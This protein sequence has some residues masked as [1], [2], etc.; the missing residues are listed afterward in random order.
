MIFTIVLW[1]SS[2]LD[3]VSSHYVS[4]ETWQQSTVFEYLSI[5]DFIGNE[6]EVL[7][8][9][10]DLDFIRLVLDLF[11]RYRLAVGLTWYEI[12]SKRIF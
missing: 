9:P 12:L 1:I 4:L 11:D 5:E 10:T 2:T 7:S 3:V 6:H 8:S